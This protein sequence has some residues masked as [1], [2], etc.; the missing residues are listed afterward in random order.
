MNFSV[1]RELWQRRATSQTQPMPPTAKSSSYSR[2]SQEFR[3]MRQKHTPDLVMDLPLTQDSI[4]N[5]SIFV[6]PATTASKA[7]TPSSLVMPEKQPSHA[8][9]AAT[10]WQSVRQQ[11]SC[12]ESP[13]MSTAAERF[14]KQ[15]QCTL[16]KNTKIVNSCTD[17][18]SGGSS[19]LRQVEYE[20]S[21]G[22]AESENQVAVDNRVS[23][24]IVDSDPMSVVTSNRNLIRAGRSDDFITLPTSTPKI[25]AKFADM[26]LTG[27]SQMTSFKPQVKVKPTILRKPVLPHPRMSPELARKQDG[28]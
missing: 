17:E 8:E 21:S 7:T 27:G 1:N 16:K 9:A 26:H 20:E 15:N 25:V 22:D 12:P 5:S 18:N 23:T 28:T 24:S 10:D 14:A 11:C 13:D 3:E 4:D 6:A 2:A 19:K